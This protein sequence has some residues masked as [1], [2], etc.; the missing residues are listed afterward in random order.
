[1]TKPVQTGTVLSKIVLGN[2]IP[3][4]QDPAPDIEDVVRH[5]AITGLA[6]CLSLRLDS[7][8][9]S[10]GSASRDHSM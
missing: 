5:L 8:N 4:R 9:W 10:I 6:G 1:M 3:A 2:T 7:L